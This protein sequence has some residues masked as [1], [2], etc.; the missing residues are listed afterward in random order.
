[1]SAFDKCLCLQSE[2]CLSERASCSAGRNNSLF[3]WLD[4]P[5][6]GKGN[7]ASGEEEGVSLSLEGAV[8][9]PSPWP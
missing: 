4:F 7:K 3:A 9:F 2:G 1:M 6:L 5:H 8:A